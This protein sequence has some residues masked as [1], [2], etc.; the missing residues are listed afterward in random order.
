MKVFYVRVR[1]MNDG[2][3]LFARHVDA[4]SSGQAAEIAVRSLGGE[5]FTTCVR[6]A[7]ALKATDHVFNRHYY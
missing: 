7:S 2:F 5:R 1:S 3:I 6:F 4:K